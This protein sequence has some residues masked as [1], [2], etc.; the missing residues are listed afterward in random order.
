MCSERRSTCVRVPDAVHDEGRWFW[1][2]SKTRMQ[3]PVYTVINSRPI[4]ANVDGTML[5]RFRDIP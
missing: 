3:I 1:C 5:Y 4:E 2:H